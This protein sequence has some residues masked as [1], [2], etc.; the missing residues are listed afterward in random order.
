MWQFKRLLERFEGGLGL[1]ER[2]LVQ[3]EGLVG[4]FKGLLGAI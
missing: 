2:S 1:F 4:Q 3:C